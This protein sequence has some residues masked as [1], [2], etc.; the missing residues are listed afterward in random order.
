MADSTTFEIIAKFRDEV[1]GGFQKLGASFAAAGQHVTGFGAKLESLARTGLEPIARISPTAASA[2]DGLITKAGPGGLAFGALGGAVLAA[3]AG[4][5]ATTR[6]VAD[7]A[8]QL[9]KMAIKTGI[10][11]ESLSALKLAAELSDS[12]LEGVVGAVR[13][14]QVALDEAGQGAKEPNEALQRLNLNVA[15]LRGLHPDQQFE[16]FATALF[17]V[18]DPAKR[19]AL[20]SKVFGKS[21]QELLP[22]MEDLAQR[23]LKGARE[24][25]DRLGLTIS[26]ET[27]RAAQQFNDDL[28]R[29]EA[30][31]GG[32]GRTIGTALLPHLTG[33]TKALDDLLQGRVALGIADE[34]QGGAREAAAAAEAME[35][36][37]SSL[38]LALQRAGERGAAGFKPVF[39]S[40]DELGAEAQ[41]KIADLQA[42]SIAASSAALKAQSAASGDALHMIDL[43]Y[44]EAIKKTNASYA[45]RAE[46][47]N[48]F[49]I[50]AEDKERLLA[51]AIIEMQGNVTVNV[52][53]QVAKR[54]AAIDGFVATAIASLTK[55]GDAF[56]SSFQRQRPDSVMNRLGL[57]IALS[58]A[59]KELAAFDGLLQ[60]GIVSQEDYAKAVEVTVG[61]LQMQG[62]TAAQLAKILTPAQTEAVQAAE[63]L[64]GSAFRVNEQFFQT[65]EAAEDYARSIG[66]AKAAVEEL[67]RTLNR[68][69]P[70]GA[71]PP[72]PP[73]LDPTKWE[74]QD[75]AR[76]ERRKKEFEDAAAEVK[77]HIKAEQE[78]AKIIAETAKVEKERIDAQRVA[79]KTMGAAEEALLATRLKGIIDARAADADATVE[80]L[81]EIG[82]VDG[83]E[84]AAIR[85]RLDGIR[86]GLQAETE[87]HGATIQNLE[88]E[89]ELLKARLALE[90]DPAK[91]TLIEAAIQATTT[92]IVQG[93]EE[94]AQATARATAESQKQERALEKVGTTG[95]QAIDAST[96]A[97]AEFFNR[98]K[99]SNAE[100]AKQQQLLAGLVS[101]LD[102]AAEARRR[103]NQA[104]GDFNRRIGQEHELARIQQAI[105][106]AR[107]HGQEEEIARQEQLLELTQQRF[108]EEN[109]G[110]EIRQ[111]RQAFDEERRRI[112][113]ALQAA[114][115][116]AIY[117]PPDIGPM[118]GP[119]LGTPSPPAGAHTG[120][121]IV[122]VHAQSGGVVPGAGSGDTVP[123]M[124]APGEA[125]LPKWLRGAL[126]HVLTTPVPAGGGML[127][128]QSGGVIVGGGGESVG[129]RLDRLADAIE[130]LLTQPPVSINFHG[131]AY[132]TSQASLRGLASQ[133]SAA[134]AEERRRRGF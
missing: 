104:E 39:L 16:V 132:M 25:A 110:R 118:T 131:P 112:A 17:K 73:L 105:A 86:L 6:A 79:G 113:A 63:A 5:L 21:V 23:G 8:D 125:V 57:E 66:V 98:M 22:L 72:P 83:A 24:E 96:R 108:A 80:R 134:A 3:G 122:A 15:E 67:S 20:A 43:E 119:G 58:S 50:S 107:A 55:L 59:K 76:A 10:S 37:V 114:R 124:G 103:V 60:A 11:V 88:A 68:A 77:A 28:K 89:L 82:D 29:L 71:V 100:I 51:T 61:A 115:I 87:R 47:I 120:G 126:L 102:Q 85:G 65:R 27:A 30:S 2:L 52:A 12:S 42:A 69:A 109:R 127:H 78:Q 7:T 53:E 45:A 81:R 32:L 123:L 111:Q 38:A 36:S 1:S 128:A 116:G 97:L 44:G 18:E 94:I 101:A 90:A 26:G 106:A 133:V 91:R 121:V 9:G 99:D 129:G 13:K 84:R 56:E 70:G 35:K 31:A 75:K 14:M 74:D 33:V 19:V 92:K 49:A 130:A 117:R 41:K 48:N 46:V 93:Q 64:R 34:F 62:A 95:K 4:L 40:L 54:Q